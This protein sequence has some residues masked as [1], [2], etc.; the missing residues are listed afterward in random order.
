MGVKDH[1]SGGLKKTVNAFYKKHER[2]SVG[3]LG[4]SFGD[5]NFFDLSEIGNIGTK[6]PD[7]NKR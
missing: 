6:K 1:K 5:E 4:Q 3:E 2:D 7:G